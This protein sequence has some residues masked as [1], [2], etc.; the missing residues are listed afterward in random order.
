MEL[1]T[2]GGSGMQ[3]SPDFKR[4]LEPTVGV[5]DRGSGVQVRVDSKGNVR[6]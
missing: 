6:T 5:F 1:I 3:L 2:G 4:A